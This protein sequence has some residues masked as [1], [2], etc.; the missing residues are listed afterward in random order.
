MLIF[1]I[2]LIFNIVQM[3][4][5]KIQWKPVNC[6]FISFSKW[7]DFLWF[8]A[9]LLWKIYYV[10]PFFNN[11]FAT[12]SSLPC[13]SCRSWTLVR[14]LSKS[15]ST[16]SNNDV[17]RPWHNSPSNFQQSILTSHFWPKM[18]M[19][20]SQRYKRHNLGKLVSEEVFSFLWILVFTENW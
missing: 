19:P 8:L 4:Y 11:I 6:K 5:L 20:Q 16:C 18:R 2:S 9:K 12:F 14:A 15:P 3:L 7:G 10:P 1:L 13:L 17:C